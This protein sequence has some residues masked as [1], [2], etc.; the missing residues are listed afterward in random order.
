MRPGPAGWI[1]RRAVVRFV[2]EPFRSA[3]DPTRLADWL[4][5]LGAGAAFSAL[6]SDLNQHTVR[7][8]QLPTDVVRIDTTT[9]NSYADVLSAQGLLQFGHSKDDPDR[10]QFQIAAAILDPL[11]MPL[12]TAV[13]P[14]NTADDP[15]YI[16]AIRSVQ[17]AFGVGGRTYVGDCKMAALATRAFVAAGRALGVGAGPASIS[18]VLKTGRGSTAAPM[19][20][21]GW[22]ARASEAA[23]ADLRSAMTF[24]IRTNDGVIGVL[25]VFCETVERPVGGVLDAI[26]LACH[27]IGR[28]LERVR[29]DDALHEATM[30]LSALAST[31]SLTGLNNRRAFQEAVD[32]DLRSADGLRRVVKIVV[33]ADQRGH[34]GVVSAEQ[35]CRGKQT[36]QQKNAAPQGRVVHAAGK[37]LQLLHT[38]G[39]QTVPAN[40]A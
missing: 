36:R 24:P 22:G 32:S 26:P 10:P 19:G 17:Q 13:V 12:A 20:T 9:A 6:E 7:V 33:P 31:D 5:R 4:S 40:G 37:S 2:G 30:E 16:P 38:H 15:L 29:A 34:H 1:S 25:A 14:G 39:G 8:Y 28:F 23:K 11:G 3:F 21:D 18:R 35:V 27:H